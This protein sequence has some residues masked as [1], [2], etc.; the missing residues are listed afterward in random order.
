MDV[1]HRPQQDTCVPRR[2]WYAGSLQDP[3]DPSHTRRITNAQVRAVSGCPV[4]SNMVTERPL[5]FFGHMAR[6]APDEDHHRAVA[7]AIRKPPSD[8]IK[9]REKTQSHAAQSHRIR[10]ETAEHW[11]F[12]CV[13]ES[14]PSRTLGFDCGHSYAQEEYAMKTKRNDND[15]PVLPSVSNLCSCHK[16]TGWLQLRLCG[17]LWTNV[18]SRKIPNANDLTHWHCWCPIYRDGSTWWSGNCRLDN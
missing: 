15:W 10:P 17:C 8:W 4:L 6:S 16:Q 1:K 11:S 18:A 14:S 7:A 2:I 3:E 13:E 12:L 5:R 9:P